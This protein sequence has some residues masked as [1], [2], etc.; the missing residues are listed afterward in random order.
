ML[1][2]Y[3]KPGVLRNP[4]LPSSRTRK[5]G[6]CQLKRVLFSKGLCRRRN[7]SQSRISEQSQ[8]LN[9]PAFLDKGL[10]RGNGHER[11]SQ[12]PCKVPSVPNPTTRKG[13]LHNRGLH[14]LLF[15]NIGVGSFTSHINRSVKALR[16]GTC[17]FLCLSEKTRQSNHLQISLQRQHF[18]LSYLKILSVGPA[19]V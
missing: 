4:T 16:D 18:P 8:F 9:L 3:F 17:G 2:Q 11:D 10:P 15:L 13:Q 14:P 5:L 19:G 12:V 1:L 6:I 7:H